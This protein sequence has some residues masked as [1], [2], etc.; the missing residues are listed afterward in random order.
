MTDYTKHINEVMDWF[1][2]GLV[3]E[4]LSSDFCVH[5]RNYDSEGELRERI[6]EKL[7]AF[8]KKDLDYIA[9][10]GWIFV[11]E[12]DHL[13]INFNLTGWETEGYTD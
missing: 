12:D 9:S 5:F 2:F 1:D 6:R 8:V 4:Y 7:E 3:F 10:G 11:K 13:S